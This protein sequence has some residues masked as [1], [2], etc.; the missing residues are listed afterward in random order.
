MKITNYANKNTKDYKNAVSFADFLN[1]SIGSGFSIITRSN[2]L[3]KDATVLACTDLI[4]STIA[5]M[6]VRN[7]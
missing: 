4:A 3:E 5:S 7:E 2:I 1:N 6:G